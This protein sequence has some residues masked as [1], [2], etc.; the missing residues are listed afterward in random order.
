MDFTLSPESIQW[1]EKVRNFVSEHILART[2]LDQHG[3]FPRDLYQ[4][5]F[6][7]G[8]MNSLIPNAYGG[9]G[10][11]FLDNILGAEECAYGDL[12]ITTSAYLARLSLGPLIGFGTEEQKRLWLT[13]MTK[14]LTFSSFCFTEPE[15]STN[16]GTRPASTIVKETDSGFVI[17]GDKWTISNGSVASVYFV[18]AR[19]ENE[20][21][22][23]SCFIIPRS[24][25]GVSASEPFKKMGQRAA[26]TAVVHFNNVQ[27]PKENMIG[28]KGQGAQIAI[29]SL[30][31]SRIG[32]G[33]M[34]LGACQRARDLA[35]KHCH[36]RTNGNGQA[37]IY[38]QDIKFRF[39]EIEAKIEM[40]RSFLYRT[41]WEYENGNE[42]TKFACSLK[43]MSA[44]IADDVTNE[45]LDLHGGLGYLEEGKIEK[46]VRDTKLLRIYEGT[47]AVQKLLI[48]DTAIRMTRERKT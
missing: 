5:A 42:A 9:I 30:V 19:F 34:A 12:G 4:K 8:I 25:E 31:S 38:E 10:R 46:I 17:S 36:T 16:L 33:A 29:K 41:V 13:P 22:G 40:L 11:S 28:R 27:I 21:S 3:H 43:L 14:E 32:I 15:G 45:C 39:A 2:D 37:I 35:K 20:E 18:F 24:A 6:D 1:K 48:A 44:Q 47:E 7:L 26:D 23:M